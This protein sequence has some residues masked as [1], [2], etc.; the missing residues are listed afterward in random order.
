M[1]NKE[2]PT[3]PKKAKAFNKKFIT[4]AELA[5]RWGLS[6]SGVYHGASDVS[7]LT[8]IPFGKKSIRY[9]LTQVEEI[10]RQKIDLAT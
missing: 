10:E 1:A 7:L 8:R 4:A 3:T 5:D 2:I 6:K 9:L